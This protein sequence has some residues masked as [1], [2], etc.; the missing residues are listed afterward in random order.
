MSIFDEI[1]DIFKNRDILSHRFIPDELPHRE[2]ELRELAAYLKHALKG[3]TP[4]HLLIL[5]HTGTGK[6]V[7]VKKILQEMRKVAG[8]KINI[9]YTIANGTPFQVLN[10]LAAEMDPTIRFTGLSFKE[11]W[12]RFQKLISNGKVSIIVL[13]EIDK[14]LLHGS[15]LLYFLSREERVCVISISNRIN[16]MDMI[17]DKRVLSSF[18]PIKITFP[19]YN[20]DQLRNILEVRAKDAFYEGVLEDGVIPLCAAYA[21]HREGDARYAL[22]LLAYAGD[23]AVRKMSDKVMIEHVRIAKR[24]LEEDFIKQSVKNLSL[25]QKLLLLAVLK[26]DGGYTRDVYTLCNKYLKKLKE[27]TLSNRRLSSLL[28]DLEM[29]GF[30]EYV[31][32]GLGK[33]RGTRWCVYLNETIDR[34]LIR[35]AL[36]ESLGEDLMLTYDTVY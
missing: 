36:K 33:G 10:D 23:E 9:M 4:P 30:V 15:D 27:D 34:N 5:G 19:K 25:A 18:N 1:P 7:T 26:C 35:E 12:N 2:E 3:S 20:A 13:D 16:V 29:Y 14:M 8:D 28:S 22:D 24:K 32:K 11:A 21:A 17:T 6:T 31:K